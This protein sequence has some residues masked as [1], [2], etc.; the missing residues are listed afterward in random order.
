[1]RL[2]T[3]FPISRKAGRRE[4]FLAL[5]CQTLKTLL[6]FLFANIQCLAV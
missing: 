4:K 3:D 2:S 1:M 5:R 6:E